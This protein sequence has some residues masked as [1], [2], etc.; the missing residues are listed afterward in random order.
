MT[1]STPQDGRP[2]AERPALDEA[3]IRAPMGGSLIERFCD[4]AEAAGMHIHRTTAAAL[5]ATL[6][7]L[8][9]PHGDGPVLLE[10]ALAEARPSLRELDAMCEHPTDAEL[11]DAA[12]GIVSAEAAIAETGSVV[13][14][15]GPGRRRGMALAPMTIIVVLDASAI[16]ADLWDVLADRAA[17]SLPSEM[18]LITGPSKTADIGMKLVTGVHG[19]GEVH[20][21]ILDDA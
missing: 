4:E 14:R 21:V 3:V 9:E 17:G 6:T 11:F 19:P 10:P 18:V 5:V 16:V 13:R 20:V 1:H 15:A 8:I 2:L 12:V 7:P